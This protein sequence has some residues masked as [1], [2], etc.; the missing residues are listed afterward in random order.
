MTPHRIAAA[1]AL[2]GV[3][4]LALTIVAAGPA[5]AHGAPTDPVSRV[6]A[7]SPEGT[8]H[9]SA[10]CRAA[11]DANGGAEFEA[12]DNLR[13]ADVRG[14]DR[15]FIPDGQLCSAGLDA[16][17]GLDIARRDWPATPLKAGAD[18]TLTYR[19]TIPHKGTFS[20]YLTKQGYDPGAP[21]RWD[22]LAAVPFAT[23]TDPELEGGAYR[24]SGRLPTGLTGRHVLYTVWRN[25]STPDTYYSCSDVVMQGDGAAQNDGQ[26]GGGQQSEAHQ[27]DPSAQGQQ[28]GPPAQEQAQ[29][30]S[31]PVQGQQSDAPVVVEPAGRQA[32]ASS[33]GEDNEPAII[34]G[35]A[36]AVL[37]LVAVG[38][39][40][41][42][43]RRAQS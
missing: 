17:A 40:V 41:L 33:A 38:V 13:V 3:V 18:F 11:V 9:A 29:Q 39:S 15:E 2:A 43:R 36:A 21:L 37:A 24:I 14:R 19:S 4:P 27:S 23:V 5:R 10:A 26:A 20:L 25:T 35:G 30:S 28:S 22:D 1:T 32:A 7:C 34:A 16:Y 31:P 12:W 6:A 8:Q 42:L